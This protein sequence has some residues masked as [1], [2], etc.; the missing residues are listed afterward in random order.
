LLAGPAAAPAAIERRIALFV[1]RMNPFAHEPSAHANRV[2]SFVSRF[3][4]IDQKNRA[5]PQLGLYRRFQ[6]PKITILRHAKS[7][8]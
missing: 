4:S 8:N 3:A 6:F 1:A 7:M 2:G 5:P